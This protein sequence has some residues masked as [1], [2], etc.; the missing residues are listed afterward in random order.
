[1]DPLKHLSPEQRLQ[2]IHYAALR[3][4][5]RRREATPDML[6]ANDRYEYVYR[7]LQRGF[8]PV[9]SIHYIG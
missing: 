9:K 7:T 1:M 3:M 6:Q 4:Q 2:R 8:H 5:G